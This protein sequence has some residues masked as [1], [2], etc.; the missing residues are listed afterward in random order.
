MQWY[1]GDW[2]KDPGVRSVSLAARGL[3]IDMLSLM[4]ECDRKGYLSLSGKP[5][6][7]DHLARMVGASTDEVSRLLTELETSGVFSR[8]DDGMIFN[9]RMVRDEES[10][11][12]SNLRVRKF[13]R[14]QR[15]RSL[16]ETPMK[17]ECTVVEDE[18]EEKRERGLGKTTDPLSA[19]GL[20]EAFCRVTVCPASAEKRRSFVKPRM[21]ELL[22]RGIIPKE[23]WDYI[24]DEQRPRTQYLWDFLRRWPEKG[25]PRSA[26]G[27]GDSRVASPRGKYEGIGTVVGPE[28]TQPARIPPREPDAS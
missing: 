4:F 17:R 15:K 26:P 6:S 28:K 19:D 3:W 24:H 13:R 16:D 5:M 9:R 2:L 18:A 12:A 14:R 22:R 10:R 23:I 20:A 25:H 11:E 27:G 21:A 8:T 1:T 7:A